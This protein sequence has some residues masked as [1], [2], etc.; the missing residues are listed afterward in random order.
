MG[1]HF[2][3]DWIWVDTPLLQPFTFDAPSEHWPRHWTRLRFM[4]SNMS[5]MAWTRMSTEIFC[6]SYNQTKFSWSVKSSP[7]HLLDMAVHSS[8]MIV[9]HLLSHTFLLNPLIMWGATIWR[10]S[11]LYP[12]SNIWI[13]QTVGVI[14][15][16]CCQYQRF[17]KG[18][19]WWARKLISSL[20]RTSFCWQPSLPCASYLALRQC[21]L[22]PHLVVLLW[23]H[24][25]L[26]DNTHSDA[27]VAD[28]AFFQ[29]CT[30]CW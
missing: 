27:S 20:L 14:A 1:A 29:K 30:L 28:D 26:V 2:S 25:P 24:W 10:H 18:K 12:G 23:L 5:S 11:F 4:R 9:K 17:L 22:G 7:T 19:P 21:H 16:N 8:A 15:W 3:S 13:V 6:T